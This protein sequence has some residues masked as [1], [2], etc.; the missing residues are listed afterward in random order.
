MKFIPDMV[1]KTFGPCKQ[2]WLRARQVL[3]YKRDKN[4]V[5]Y[6]LPQSLN[7][8]SVHD[9]NTMADRNTS[10]AVFEL[11]ISRTSFHSPCL[12]QVYH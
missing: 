6:I 9:A 4:I 8:T 7:L 1:I 11:M 2:K 5:L 3:V 10:N 12:E